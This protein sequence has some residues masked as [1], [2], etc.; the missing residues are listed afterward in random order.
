MDLKS[1]FLG[2]LGTLNKHIARE[3]EVRERVGKADVIKKL[4]KL[5]AAEGFALEELLGV[6]P[7]PQ[8]TAPANAKRGRKVVAQK[9]A[10][11]QIRYA[12]PGHRLTKLPTRRAHAHAHR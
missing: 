2:E 12:H 10:P 11:L 7:Q 1:F 6:P 8:A 9:R 3:V 5:T 4:R